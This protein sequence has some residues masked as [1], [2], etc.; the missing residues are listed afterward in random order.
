MVLA[1]VKAPPGWQRGA[2]T[3]DINASEI[4]QRARKSSREERFGI[5][6]ELSIS[7]QQLGPATGAK[8]ILLRCNSFKAAYEDIGLLHLQFLKGRQSRIHSLI[9]AGGV[10]AGP[11]MG[12]PCSRT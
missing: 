2:E 12:H 3:V 8:W 6:T 9:R 10:L 4:R 1:A 11:P 5:E 7:P